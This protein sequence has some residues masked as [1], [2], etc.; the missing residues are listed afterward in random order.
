MINDA[1][2]TLLTFAAIFLFIYT[3]KHHV[4][5]FF[6]YCMDQAH[7]Q[8]WTSDVMKKADIKDMRK[9]NESNE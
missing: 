9:K 3:F 1:T 4:G 5:A 6:N 7:K 8:E 2:I